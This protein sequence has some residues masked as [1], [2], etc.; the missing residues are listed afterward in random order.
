MTVKLFISSMIFL[1]IFSQSVAQVFGNMEW[2]D[3]ET[4]LQDGPLAT[5]V[6]IFIDV[7]QVPSLTGEYTIDQN[8]IVDL[9]LIGNVK[10]LE[11]TPASFARI[12]EVLYEKDYLQNPKITV[13]IMDGSTPPK[14]MERSF[15]PTIEKQIN[16]V[17][18]NSLEVAAPEN[19]TLEPVISLGL[20]TSDI[21]T[22]PANAPVNEL[23]AGIDIKGIADPSMALI[24]IKTDPQP[25]LIETNSSLE[26]TNWSLG[27]DAREVIHF[28][29]EGEMAG[30][31]GCNNFF[32]TYKERSPNIDIRLLGATFLD[33]ADGTKP[34]EFID[35]LETANSFAVTQNEL[36]LMDKDNEIVFSFS[37]NHFKP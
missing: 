6:T 12:L 20:S 25:I 18:N 36:H 30:T 22:L 28:L 35:L 26:G 23:T 2:Q 29:S 16:N 7:K 10:A 1:C 4:F 8:G 31:V 13:K 17:S 33:C 27:S 9:P 32:A 34:K 14:Q 3:A 11:Q 24:D 15:D 5:G 37:N 21:D 19:V